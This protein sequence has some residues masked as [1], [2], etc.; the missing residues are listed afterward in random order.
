MTSVRLNDRP[1]FHSTG[2][3]MLLVLNVLFSQLFVPE[4]PPLAALGL[5]VVKSPAKEL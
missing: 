1:R 4:L 2:S 3:Y 5:V